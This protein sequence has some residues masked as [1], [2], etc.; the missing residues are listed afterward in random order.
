MPIKALPLPLCLTLWVLVHM[1]QA[2]FT[3]ASEISRGP[4]GIFV[5]QV[6]TCPDLFAAGL[7]SVVFLCPFWFIVNRLAGA[8]A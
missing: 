5:K 4:F 8:V 3:E 1:Q 2:A 7:F 6:A